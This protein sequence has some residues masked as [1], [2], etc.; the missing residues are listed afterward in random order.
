MQLQEIYINNVLDDFDNNILPWLET[1]LKKQNIKERDGWTLIVETFKDKR[2]GFTADNIRY[3]LRK[4]PKLQQYKN[5]RQEENA[6]KRI[7]KTSK[8]S[9]LKQLARK[10]IIELQNYAEPGTNMLNAIGDSNVEKKT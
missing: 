8:K 10:S 3:K 9:I 5:H 4:M 2:P 7:F 6:K 1:E